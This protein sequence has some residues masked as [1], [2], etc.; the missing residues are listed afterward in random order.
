MIAPID[1]PGRPATISRVRAEL[2]PGGEAPLSYPSQLRPAFARPTVFAVFFPA[3]RA[4]SCGQLFSCSS[5][6]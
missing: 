4:A 3:A 6:G 1:G 2:K 5:V